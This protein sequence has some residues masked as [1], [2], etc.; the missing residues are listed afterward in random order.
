MLREGLQIQRPGE[1]RRGSQWVWSPWVWCIFTTVCC[2]LMFPLLQPLPDRFWLHATCKKQA[3]HPSLSPCSL[4]SSVLCEHL[5][6]SS[7]VFSVLIG[8][9]W[10]WILISLPSMSSLSIL[11]W[12]WKYHYLPKCLISSQPTCRFWYEVGVNPRLS[13]YRFERNSD[14]QFY[15]QFRFISS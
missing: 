7:L 11:L 3:P 5:L 4:C 8:G 9:L 6:L 14:Q 10:H 13:I 12:L 15:R 2:G 1:H